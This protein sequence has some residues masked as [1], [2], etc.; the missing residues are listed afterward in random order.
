[1]SHLHQSIRT[2]LLHQ[3]GGYVVVGCCK[4]P[5]K[6]N[7]CSVAAALRS[8]D[9]VTLDERLR[10]I[11]R[12]VARREAFLHCKS[13][14]ERLECGTHLPLA[15]H[16]LVILE[17]I[18]VSTTDISPDISGFRL[19]C[20]KAGTQIGLEIADTVIRSHQGVYITLVVPGKDPHLG[21]FGETLLYLRLAETGLLHVLVAVAPAASPAHQS[22]Y[23]IF[24]STIRKREVLA[25]LEVILEQRLKILQMLHGS[26]LGI[27]LH[28]CVKR[29][30]DFQAVFLQDI[31]LPIRLAVL[32]KPAVQRILLPSYGILTI[33]VRV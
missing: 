7:G 28:L 20:H 32:V 14:K 8:P 21:L 33:V 6:C 10:K 5:F 22:F 1:M 12:N 2:E 23:D 9:A 24:R 19:H 3:I 13:V 29:G 4:S 15:L 16:D 18:V 26:L 11:N 25:V 17:V 31:F 27:A 30:D